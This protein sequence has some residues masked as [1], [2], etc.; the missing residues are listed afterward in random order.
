MLGG[1]EDEEGEGGGDVEE[2]DGGR[3][4]AEAALEGGI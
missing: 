2:V 3:A 1:S 4:E